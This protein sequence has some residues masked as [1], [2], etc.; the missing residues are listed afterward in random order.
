MVQQRIVPNIWCVG[1]AA[2]AGEFYAAALPDTTSEI[3]SRYPETDL[4]PFQEPLAGKPLTVAVS[5]AGYRLTLVNAGDEFSP[6]RSI[7]LMLNFDPLNYAG[8]AI[9]AR[10]QLDA[11][12]AALADGGEVLM[13]LGEYPFSA[14]YG[15]VADRFGVNWQVMLTD[16][17]GDPRPFV[18]PSLL[19]GA[20]AQNR[21]RE[22][23]DFYTRV[24]PGAAP[25]VR[26]PYGE[27]TGPATADALMFGEFR[28]GDQWFAAMDSGV[29]QDE[30][31]T[32]GVSLEVQCR[33]QGEIDRL[34]D[35]LSAVPEAEQCGWLADRFGVSWQIVPENMGELMARPDAFAH[36]LQM[37]KLVIADF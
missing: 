31:F 2:E 36:M 14:R 33:D 24:F 3:E 22:A 23:I 6:N 15:W 1:T 7:S 8:G 11:T 18:I 26:V 16:P 35:A 30:S 37:K 27:P 29:T 10:A 28:I 21:A 5:V 34:W 17:T 20:A 25:G 4:L 13:P 19:F 12:W 32:C 9:A